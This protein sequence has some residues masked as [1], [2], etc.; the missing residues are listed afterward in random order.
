[1]DKEIM[2][3][4]T[5]IQ[6][7][8]GILRSTDKMAAQFAERVQE[9]VGQPVSHDTIVAAMRQMSA[10]TLTMEKVVDKLKRQL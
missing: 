1:M 5:M 6:E 9:R 8:A 2:T 10:R 3:E 4:E 7:M